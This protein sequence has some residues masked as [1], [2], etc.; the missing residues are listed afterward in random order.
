GV[1]L[2]AIPGK[3]LQKPGRRRS[4][5]TTTV[6]KP[7]MAKA[8]A[9]FIAEK[10]LPS[11]LTALVINNTLPWLSDR[12]KQID[13]RIKRNASACRDFGVST[14]T[15]GSCARFLSFS[16]GTVPKVGSPKN[17]SA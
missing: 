7:S 16:S 4:A 3:A 11:L 17:S 6:L 5:S 1:L 13:A 12:S 10:D 9:V 2:S 15:K 14:T 8:A